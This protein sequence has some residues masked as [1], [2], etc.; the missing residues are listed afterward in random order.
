MTQTK[1]QRFTCDRCGDHQDVESGSEPA[2]WYEISVKHAGKAATQ[3]L[4]ICE[5]CIE[6]F[7]V[8]FKNETADSAA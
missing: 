2:S 5:G 6:D 3:K 1:F 8:W 7:G 4:D